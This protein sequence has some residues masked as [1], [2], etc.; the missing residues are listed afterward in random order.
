MKHLNL[1]K[2]LILTA[3]LPVMWSCD[4]DENKDP[5]PNPGASAES[6]NHVVARFDDDDNQVYIA[7]AEDL[8][9]GSLTFKNNGYHLNPVRS[10]RVFTDDLGWVY[11]F[12]YGGG[13]LKKLQYANGKYTQ[14]RE[15]SMT[16]VMGGNAYVRPCKI[17][18]ETILIHNANTYDVDSTDTADAEAIEAGIT[19]KG[20]LYVT[21]VSLPE[22]VISEILDTWSIPVT[23]WDKAEKAHVRRV[24]V[25][26]VL[27]DKIYYG[28]ARRSADEN[29]ELTGMHSIVLDYPSLKNPKYIRSELANG[30]TNGYRGGNMHA[31]SGY[32]YQANRS[33]NE[34][35]PTKLVRLKDGEYDTAWEFNLT[36]ALGEAFYTSNWYHAENG[37]CYM[38]AAFYN[39]EDENNIWGV[40]R[41]DVPN[42]TVVK[43]NVPMSNLFAYQNGVVK[44]GR[45]HMAICPQGTGTDFEPYVYSF[46]IQSTNPNAVEKGLKLDKGNI[47][48]EGIF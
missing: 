46:D 38:P 44:D 32:V 13:Y 20:V 36:E 37:I 35:E 27:D 33:A 24:D 23:D 16:Q 42:K 2:Y 30:N 34:N 8:S 4:K 12:D 1:L 39:A 11:V 43:M 18:E 3:L 31:I 9:S 14:V 45:F 25:P 5:G 6:V 26:T 15:L 21:R 41:V 10:A 19:T 17:N 48:I 40:L 47:R 28:V 29:M 7:P 22:V